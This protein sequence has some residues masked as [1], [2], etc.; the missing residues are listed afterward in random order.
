MAG[1]ADLS[2][3]IQAT[4][5]RVTVFS[6]L[7]AV[8]QYAGRTSANTRPHQLYW[9]DGQMEATI[10]PCTRKPA[11]RLAVEWGTDMHMWLHCS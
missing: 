1:Q 10:L 3:C 9:D 2:A 7:G 5:I 8:L 11:M 6:H 4:C